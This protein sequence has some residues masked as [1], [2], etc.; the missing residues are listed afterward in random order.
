MDKQNLLRLF[1]AELVLTEPC[2]FR[3]ELPRRRRI[4]GARGLIWKQT[5]CQVSAFCAAAGTGGTLA[6][7]ST[8]LKEQDP[9]IQCYLIDCPTSSLYHY[10]TVRSRR[11]CPLFRRGVGELSGAVSEG[12]VQLAIARAGASR[13]NRMMQGFPESCII[14]QVMI[15][16]T[17]VTL[18]IMG[19][20]VE[21]FD[22][23]AA[24]VAKARKFEEEIAIETDIS[25]LE[26]VQL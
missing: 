17:G 22:L 1:G 10:I 18:G 21:N 12:L 8:Y 3:V 26:T 6:G 5:D 25:E 9:S 14:T 24:G 16:K 19:M 13:C 4:T 23:L 11:F 15:K 2:K 20:T 7:I